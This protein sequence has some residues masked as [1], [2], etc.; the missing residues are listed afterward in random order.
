MKYRIWDSEEKRFIHPFRISFMNERLYRFEYY[1]LYPCRTP[2]ILSGSS[3]DNGDRIDVGYRCGDIDGACKPNMST[4]IKDSN[5][6][7]IYEGDIIDVE[8]S[9]SVLESVGR[10]I[11]C[12]GE[13]DTNSLCNSV[14]F[15]GKCVSRKRFKS[16]GVYEED[17]CRDNKMISQKDV[18]GRRKYIVVGNIYQNPKL[19]EVK[20]DE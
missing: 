19:F 15:F 14:G 17:D 9:V 2:I 4:G 6:V 16:N 1:C 12:F 7:E 11:I 13:F 20:K 18:N 10:F 8:Y 3:D 5:G